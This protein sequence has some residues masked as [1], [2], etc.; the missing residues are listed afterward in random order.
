[1]AQKEHPTCWTIVNTVV[2]TAANVVIAVGVGWAVAQYYAGERT[3]RIDQTLRLLNLGPR[4]ISYTPS[5]EE[6]HNN[7]LFHYFPDRFIT[8]MN[9]VMS[10]QDAKA[11]YDIGEDRDKHPDLL[12]KYITARD[13]LNRVAALAFAYLHDLGD[14]QMLA[15]SECVPMVRSA[16][17]FRA[18]I[19]V[20]GKIYKGQQSWQVIPKAVEHM[21]VDFPEAC[22]D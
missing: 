17:Y 11:L 3:S 15:E 2:N 22:K 18:L 8:P 16:T 10:E 1:M 21:K 9:S 6:A 7:N 14:R 5:D 20:F 13:E 19:D 4:S 12:P